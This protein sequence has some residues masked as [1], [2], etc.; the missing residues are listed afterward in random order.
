[1]A[2]TLGVCASRPDG[3][4]RGSNAQVAPFGPLVAAGLRRPASPPSPPPPRLPP[5][6]SPPPPPPPTATPRCRPDGAP[7]PPPFAPPAPST[8][9]TPPVI[10][11]GGTWRAWKA[12]D[13]RG[14]VEPACADVAAAL[15]GQ[16]PPPPSRADAA[17]LAADDDATA[18]FAYLAGRACTTVYEGT[19]CP[20]G[21]RLHMTRD[22]GGGGGGG[23][24]GSGAAPWDP[25]GGAGGGPLMALVLAHRYPG[26]HPER[27]PPARALFRY[28]AG[29]RGCA[30]WRRGVFRR[31]APLRGSAALP[32]PGDM[33]AHWP[34]ARFAYA[35]LPP[36]PAGHPAVGPPGA[37]LC[38]PGDPRAVAGAGGGAW[39]GATRLWAPARCRM[40][41]R[42]PHGRLHACLAGVRL[43]VVGD[44][45]LRQFAARLIATIR[46][47]PLA[48]EHEHMGPWTYAWDGDRDEIRLHPG[49]PL[50]PGEGRPPSWGPH[51]VHGTRLGAD[52]PPPDEDPAAFYLTYA[53]DGKLTHWDHVG[54]LMA[55]LR[56]THVLLGSN[57][58]IAKNESAAAPG[59]LQRGLH[60]VL[61]R[62]GAGVSALRGVLW[63]E[64]PCHAPAAA[65]G[66]VPYQDNA[67]RDA[68]VVRGLR[69]LW[70]AGLDGAGGRDDGAAP[71]PPLRVPGAPGGVSL[72]FLPTCAVARAAP[73]AWFVADGVHLGCRVDA[74]PSPHGG[75][76]SPVGGVKVTLDW[77]CTD[78]VD[79]T[80]V[81][82][83]L[84]GLCPATAGAVLDEEDGGGG[85]G[86]DGG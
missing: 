36:L 15:A 44:S 42:W 57:Y 25:A 65:T 26:P 17:R 37:P 82:V 71:P 28:L 53:F 73:P 23:G 7:P 9:G 48:V 47:A 80:G 43:L 32:R 4:G 12:V 60:G 86:G 45:P 6:R 10:Y 64:F 75:Q 72:G 59:R 38:G 77:D 20:A 61:A 69:A 78:A 74:P 27:S 24:N 1:V 5:P 41:Y 62:G 3:C 66:A 35:D 13:V 31:C 14:A 70:A 52:L 84:A 11:P 33:V 46:G 79:A 30:V 49:P 34:H 40:P 2:A 16:P 67:D 21:D 63:Y 18:A 85:G 58:W 54:D 39:A 50:A 81:R 29:Q 76:P 51:T 56:P 68:A 83:L 19:E 8:A 22:D 55:A